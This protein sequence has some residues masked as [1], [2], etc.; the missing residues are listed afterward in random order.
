MMKLLEFVGKV[1]VNL[2]RVNEIVLD[3]FGGLGLIMIV[4]D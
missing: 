4:F 2:F 1:I 3:L